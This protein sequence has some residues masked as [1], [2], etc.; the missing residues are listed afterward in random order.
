MPFRTAHSQGQFP[1]PSNGCGAK[2]T[3]LYE[4][5]RIL[6]DDDAAFLVYSGTS[7]LQEKLRAPL[8]RQLYDEAICQVK[9]N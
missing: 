4:D 2:E 7:S 1:P 6:D 5:L 3:A 8:C 9:E